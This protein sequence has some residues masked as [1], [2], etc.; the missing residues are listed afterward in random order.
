MTADVVLYTE[1]YASHAGVAVVGPI[2]NRHSGLKK[3]LKSILLR[4]GIPH[5]DLVRTYLGKRVFDLVKDFGTSESPKS[6][7][8]STTH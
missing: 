2:I 1:I 4:H 8:S 6:T 5:I 7:R 3:Q